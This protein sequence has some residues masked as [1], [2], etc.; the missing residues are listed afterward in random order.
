MF[1]L[2]R[3]M[4]AP[5]TGKGHRNS[6]R[7]EKRC[8]SISWEGQDSRYESKEQRSSKEGKPKLGPGLTYRKLYIKAPY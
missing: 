7:A 8:K 6:K 5:I 3:R 4:W 1:Q 2:Q